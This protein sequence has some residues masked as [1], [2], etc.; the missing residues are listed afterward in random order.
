[1]GKIN[2]NL[3]DLIFFIEIN[4]IFTKNQI[5]LASYLGWKIKIEKQIHRMRKN[6]WK[7]VG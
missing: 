6:M 5:I 2:L 7:K 4:R 3:D 1:M